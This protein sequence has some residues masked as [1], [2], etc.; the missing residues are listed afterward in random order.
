MLA[1]SKIIGGK[2]CANYV[3]HMALSSESNK[4]WPLAGF[5][6]SFFPRLYIKVITCPL[7]TPALVNSYYWYVQQAWRDYSLYCNFSESI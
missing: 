2:Y 4:K 6:K 5:L 7:G 1:N 3:D